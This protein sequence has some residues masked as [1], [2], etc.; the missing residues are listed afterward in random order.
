MLYYFII[1]LAVLSAAGAQMLLKQGARKAY[2]PWWRQYVNGWVIGGYAIMFAAMVV[3]IWC[4]H[5]GVCLKD[6]SIL[7]STSYLFVPLL[8]FVCFGEKLSRR[9]LLAIA[10]ILSGVI[11]FFL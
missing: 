8:A 1:L 7:E 4:M 6:L 3:N 9:K 2:Q 11:I 5:R 10:I